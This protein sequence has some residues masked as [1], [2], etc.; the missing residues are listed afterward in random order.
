MNLRG[1]IAFPIA[2]IAGTSVAAFPDVSSQ[3]AQDGLV[4][5][6]S[7]S[8]DEFYLRR[9][10]NL[11][12]YR[13][14]MIDPVQVKFDKG[15]LKYARNVMRPVGEENVERIAEDIAA[16]AQASISE[17]FRARGLEIVGA[18]APGV[19]RLS[20]R[21][22]DLYVNAPER[23]SPWIKNN[24]T[25]EA[26]QAVLL[27]EARDSASDALL[28]RVVHRGKALRMVRFTW[29]NDASNRIWFDALIRDWA[30]NCA[31]ELQ[32]GASRP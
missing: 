24:F 29:T 30:M 15:W 22:A 26:G 18:P 7:R 1:L 11:A 14:V 20:A 28:G 12:A 17:A 6:H 4:A 32:A 16:D 3:A 23:P 10:A 27:L 9:D 21:V 25:R 5:V 8:L 31:A 13:K 19:L 2:M